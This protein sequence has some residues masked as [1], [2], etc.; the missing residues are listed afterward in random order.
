[1][2]KNI[3]RHLAGKGM[4]PLRFFNRT[5][6]KG[7]A[8]EA[9]GGVRCPSVAAVAA[10]SD[11]IFISASDDKAV[12]SIIEQIIASG[13]GNIAG[14]TIA[15]KTIVDTTTVHPDTTAAVAE[16][17]RKAGAELVA[18]PVFGAT[19]VAEEGRLLVAFAGSAAAFERVSPFLKGVIAREVLRA[20][21]APEKAMLLKTTG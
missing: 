16:K 1:M 12:E 7:D 13:D 10:Y 6:S 11:V 4:P 21:E 5:A 18:A 9:L 17:L 8:L 3:H 14:K 15:G 19:P 2:A 20:G